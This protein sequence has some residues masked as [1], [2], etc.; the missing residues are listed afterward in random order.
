M[1]AVSNRVTGVVR[2]CASCIDSAKAPIAM[3]KAP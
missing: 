2:V 3:K 1:H